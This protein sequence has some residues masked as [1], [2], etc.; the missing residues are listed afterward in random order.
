MNVDTMSKSQLIQEIYKLS[1]K[2]TEL[3]MVLKAVDEWRGLD[4]DGITDPLRQ[5]IKN[6]LADVDR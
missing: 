2:I 6:V 1:S 3:R 4:G 5:H